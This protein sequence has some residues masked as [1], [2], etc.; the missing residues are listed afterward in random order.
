MGQVN[1]ANPSKSEPQV[2]TLDVGRQHHLEVF[3]GPEQYTRQ[4][5][6]DLLDKMWTWLHGEVC[7]LDHGPDWDKGT[8]R[9]DFALAAS[10]GR[11]PA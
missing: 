8:C 10:F 11:H 4:E 3:L 5:A 9:K 7:G 6:E 2:S 1:D